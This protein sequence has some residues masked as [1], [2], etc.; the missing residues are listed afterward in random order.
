MSK[1]NMALLKGIEDT[2]KEISMEAQKAEDT[3]KPLNEKESEALKYYRQYKSGT[4]TQDEIA[5]KV[6]WKDKSSVSRAFARIE[7]EYP[8]LLQ[9]P[10]AGSGSAVKD[11][12]GQQ[13]TK[14]ADMPQEGKTFIIK[15]QESEPEPP[16]KIT[17]MIDEP[18]PQKS[19]EAEKRVLIVNGKTEPEKPQETAQEKPQKPEK[20]YIKFN[21]GQYTDYVK[22]M[23]GFRQTNVTNYIQDL[24]A[25]DMEKNAEI[26]KKLKNM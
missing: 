26:Y 1:I 12:E 17:L 6:G 5:K 10:E 16:K 8:E 23:A 4:I 22:T 20:N 19:T 9:E 15:R 24:I 3:R 18:E 14:T 21:L 11:T 25:E 13:E 2:E 7:K